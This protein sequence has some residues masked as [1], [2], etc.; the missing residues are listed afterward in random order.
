MASFPRLPASAADLPQSGAPGTP[1]LGLGSPWTTAW[2]VALALIVI[3]LARM[4][5]TSRTL[6]VDQ[7]FCAYAIMYIMH[8]IEQYATTVE[9]GIHNI[10]H[11]IICIL[12]STCT[13]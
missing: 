3:L 6:L 9:A 8:S 5:T 2:P 1:W 10:M 13:Y 7:V 4:H 12:Y 11:S